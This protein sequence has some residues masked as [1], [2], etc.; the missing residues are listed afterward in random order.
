MP[1][2]QNAH[3]IVNAGFQFKMDSNNTIKSANIV[4]GNISSSF[5]RAV[6]TEKILGGLK[7]DDKAL[8]KAL[9]KLNDEIT[10]EDV[11][12]EPSPE[13]R[14]AIALG[15]FY[16]VISIITFIRFHN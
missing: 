5:I 4:F 15:L 14:K 16:K 3:A 6:E 8:Q 10:P 7:L 11:P 2:A 12:P 13:C 1:R 9:K